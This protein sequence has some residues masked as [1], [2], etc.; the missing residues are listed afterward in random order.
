MVSITVNTGIHSC[1]GLVMPI[2]MSMVVSMM[3]SRVMDMVMRL[4]VGGIMS[5]EVVGFVLMIFM[6][7][8]VLSEGR[9]VKGG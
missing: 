3:V 5:L 2:V 4:R 8:V 1:D 7:M 6:V 9:N